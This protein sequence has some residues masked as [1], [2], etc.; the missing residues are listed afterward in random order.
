MEPTPLLGT[1]IQSSK[2]SD[3]YQGDAEQLRRFGS[4]SPVSKGHGHWRPFHVPEVD[5]YASSE[6]FGLGSD[7]RTAGGQ[8]IY[9]RPICNDVFPFKSSVLIMWSLTD[10]PTPGHQVQEEQQPFSL[11]SLAELQGSLSHPQME[12]SILRNLESGVSRITCRACIGLLPVVQQLVSEVSALDVDVQ[13]AYVG[14][15]DQTHRTPDNV[16]HGMQRALEWVL[17]VVRVDRANIRDATARLVPSSAHIPERSSSHAISKQLSAPSPNMKRTC[18]FL[19]DDEQKARKRQRSGSLYELSTR[20]PTSSFTESDRA[21]GQYRGGQMQPLS[22]HCAVSSPDSMFMPPLSP[23]MH[24]P[25]PTR[26]LPSPSSLNFQFAPPT[27]PPISS[28]STSMQTSVQTSAHTAHLQELQHQVTLKTL[29]LQTL[30]N[31]Y[32]TLLAKLDRQRT[33][34]LALEKKFEVSDAEINNLTYQK[35]DLQNQ[36]TALE[37]Q[38]EQIREDREQE[39]EQKTKE[40]GQYT[41]IMEMASRL[42]AKGAEDRKK[43]ATEKEEL[44][45]KIREL[46]SPPEEAREF[47]SPVI[48]PMRERTETGA[49]E[50]IEKEKRAVTALNVEVEHLRT[51]TRNLE[52]VLSDMVVES[53]TLDNMTQALA[54]PLKRMEGLADSALG[55]RPTSPAATIAVTTA[56]A[57]AATAAVL[58]SPILTEGMAGAQPNLSAAAP[59]APTPFTSGSATE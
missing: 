59:E 9:T 38:L 17:D 45:C 33:K 58:H 29:A 48:A 47:S 20:P 52:T 21:R 27:L 32:T 35:E 37:T 28:P 56:L 11:P 16:R 6:M 51:R 54:S 18:D 30:Q 24:A 57:A 53:R 25:R 22:P 46:A 49:V 44:K 5:Q 12:R 42:Q 23:P 34:S 7:A 36:V 1:R 43:W 14:R 8:G 39:W 4:Q 31:E 55:G 3:D 50:K 26:M 15:T 13:M 2:P 40:G 10:P 41:R 19:E